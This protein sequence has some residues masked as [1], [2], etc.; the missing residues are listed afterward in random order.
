MKTALEEIK[1]RLS[2]LEKL[3]NGRPS[4]SL[5]NSKKAFIFRNIGWQYYGIYLYKISLGMDV[6]GL[7]KDVIEMNKLAIGANESNELLSLE[8]IFISKLLLTEDVSDVC[9]KIVELARANTDEYVDPLIIVL[10]CLR[11][12]ENYEQ[13]MDWFRKKENEKYTSILSGSSKAITYLINRDEDNLA[14]TLNSML[15]I[16]HKEANNR[17][18]GIYNSCGSFLSFAPFLILELA[19]HLGMNVKSKISENKQVLKL[20]LSSPAD[21]PN[22]P[23]NIKMPI[24]VDYLTAKTNLE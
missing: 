16:H 21:F 20:G 9:A 15:L 2:Y 22:L 8:P 12:G 1:F 13:Y 11:R 4:E 17:H 6:D 10:S 7:L 24:E 14:L 19:E 23:K 3:S 5:P 18:S